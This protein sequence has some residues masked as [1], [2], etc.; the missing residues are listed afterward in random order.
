MRVLQPRLHVVHV[1]LNVMSISCRLHQSLPLHSSVAGRGICRVSVEAQSRVHRC[2]HAWQFID[3]VSSGR[4]HVEGKG[5]GKG[6]SGASAASRS[7]TR[8]AQCSRGPRPIDA[9]GLF[10]SFD[11]SAVD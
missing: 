4:L 8:V 9:A 1:D 6:A 2:E 3:L 5:K 11:V 7:P 10:E